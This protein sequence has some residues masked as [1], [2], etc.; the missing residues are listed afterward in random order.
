[1]KTKVLIIGFGN[2]AQRH[3]KN[4]K[5]ILPQSEFSVLSKSRKIFNKKLR[6][7]NNLEEAKI[8]RP[9]VT[10]ICSPANT[11]IQYA[12]IFSEI[13]SNIFIEK[14]VAINSNQLK[15]FLHTVKKKKITILTG[16]NLRFENSLNLF[17][18]IINSKKNRTN[19]FCKVRCWTIFAILE[20]KFI[21]KI[22]I[23]K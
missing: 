22:C 10:I 16:Y 20:K 17:K 18:K 19:T 21:Y 5:K 23:C 15:D 6:F 14:P 7:L 3:Y 4:L 9:N 13:N 8:F 2:I 1:M 11:H 12:K